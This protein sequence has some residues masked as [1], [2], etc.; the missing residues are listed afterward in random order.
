M[1][2]LLVFL[3]VGHS[4]L[5]GQSAPATESL[6][7]KPNFL[8]GE[9]K[10]YLVIEEQKTSDLFLYT[11][12]KHK[13]IAQF[14]ILD[15]VSGYTINFSTKVTEPASNK[16]LFQ[17]VID[18]LRDSINLNYKL[19]NSGW[20]IDLS[21]YK[22]NQLRVLKKFYSIISANSFSEK[23][24]AL[25][26]V[27]ENKL[28]QADGL[29]ILLTPMMMFNEI[30]ITPTFRNQKDYHPSSTVNIFYQPQIAGTM[31]TYLKSYNKTNNIADLS[32]DFIGNSDS[33]LNKFTPIFQEVY[34]AL[35]GKYLK[36]V[37]YKM[38]FNIYSRY[39]FQIP[40]SFPLRISKKIIIT[41]ISKTTT[42]IKMEMVD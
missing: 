3:L 15:T 28:L 42:D 16:F 24:R 34:F 14:K 2:L 37:P 27:L 41:Y 4:E 32:V 39:E 29:E 25:L 26:R 22:E 40:G 31:V 8:P 5:F 36:E 33:A 13:F 17:S 30:Y 1:R 10:T 12:G 21:N 18:Q 35:K 38:K 11:K 6:N 23:D 7:I 20:L 9:S 19:N